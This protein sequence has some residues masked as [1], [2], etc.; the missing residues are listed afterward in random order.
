[1]IPWIYMVYNKD[2]TAPVIADPSKISPNLG[3]QCKEQKDLIGQPHSVSLNSSKPLGAQQ[4]GTST[5]I[6][7]SGMGLLN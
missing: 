2:F 5:N 4:L 7:K 1:M 3:Q 6:N